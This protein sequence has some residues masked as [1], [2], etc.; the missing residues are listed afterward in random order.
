MSA[1]YYLTNAM[2]LHITVENNPSASKPKAFRD[3]LKITT[4]DE[5]SMEVSESFIISVSLP[6]A[7]PLQSPPWKQVT[8]INKPDEGNMKKAVTTS[9]RTMS[10]KASKKQEKKKSAATPKFKKPTSHDLPENTKKQTK[11]S[12]FFNSVAWHVISS[13]EELPD[14]PPPNSDS[15]RNR[16]GYDSFLNADG[17]LL[18]SSP[19]RE[20]VDDNVEP[21]IILLSSNNNVI[22]ISDSSDC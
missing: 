9:S 8:A 13:S 19:I 15:V 21:S 17:P 6:V 22:Y 16:V 7:E 1:S 14:I 20:S 3:R 2:F 18:S 12:D 10:K 5:S 4:M 11:V